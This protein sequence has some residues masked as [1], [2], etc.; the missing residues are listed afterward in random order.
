MGDERSRRVDDALATLVDHLLP[1]FT[2]E[3]DAS[4]EERREEGLDLTKSIL[5][6]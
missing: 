5:D 2:D 4:T 6:G 1:K 3:E